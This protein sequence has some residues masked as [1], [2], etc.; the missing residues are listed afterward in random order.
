MI[1]VELPNI[2]DVQKYIASLKD[3]KLAALAAKAA[4]EIYTTDILDWIRMGQAFTSRTG[5]TEQSI[6]W[7]PEGQGALVYANARTAWFRERGT[8]LFGPKKAKYRIAP[9]KDKFTFVNGKSETSRK[10]LLIPLAG[11]HAMFRKSVMHPGSKATPFFFID[12][13][14]RQQR[15]LESAKAVV[16]Y[17]LKQGKP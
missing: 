9:S 12:L 1:A 2:G 16:E 14:G 3:P 15:M 6:S 13:P 5:A 10:A 7:R 17:R 8:G 11:G 4:A